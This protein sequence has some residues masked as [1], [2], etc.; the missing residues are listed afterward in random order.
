LKNDILRLLKEN[1]DGYVSGGNICES[2]GVSR[3]AIWKCINQ[4]KEEGYEIESVPKHGYK[5]LSCPDVLTYE[6]VYRKLETDK[7][8]RNIVHFDTV[9]STN[10]KAKNLAVATEHGTVVISEEQTIGKGR[11]G[12]SF[13]SPKNKGIWMS[14]ILKPDIEPMKVSLITQIGAA[15]VNKALINMG[16]E[17][18]I[19]WPNDIIINNKKVCGIL[20]EMSCELTMVNFVVLGIGINVNVDKEDF[21]EEISNVATSLKLETKKKIDRKK[22]VAYILNN[23][24]KLY[25]DYVDRDDIVKPISIC[26]ERSILLGK[27]IQVIK[28]GEAY[29]AKA[30]DIKENGSLVVQYENGEI[31]ELISGE[32]SIRGKEGYV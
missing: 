19:K 11:L 32:V 24:E 8:G 14:I 27:E 26:K 5:L 6:E 13:V 23:F 21:G 7:I 18:F 15:A 28:K 25:N 2:F 9:D 1:K 4:L 12:R 17:S 16:I 10:E 29:K 20:T 22:I 3:T 31:E 30:L